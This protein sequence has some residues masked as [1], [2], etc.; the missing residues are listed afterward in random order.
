MIKLAFEMNRQE[1]ADDSAG[2]VGILTLSLKKKFLSHI[3]C[4]NVGL[5]NSHTTRNM[6]TLM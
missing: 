4:R 2:G 5:V 1:I 3:T 6:S